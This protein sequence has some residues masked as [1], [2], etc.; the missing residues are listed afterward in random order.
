VS[1]RLLAVG[2]LLGATAST[3]LGPFLVISLVDRGEGAARAA[4]LLA[5]G[6]WL[7]IGGRIVAGVVSDKIPRPLAHVRAVAWMLLACG[8][9]MAVLA[10]AGSAAAV[11]V[12]TLVAM[13]FGWSWPGLLHHAV[14]ATHPNSPAQATS[15]MQTGTYLGSV[16]GPLAFGLAADRWSFSVAWSGAAVMALGSVLSLMVG[17][18]RIERR[19]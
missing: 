18:R 7:V 9:G 6:G 1:L 16:A 10:W 12:G 5:V 2:G 14:I 11:V 17:V 8:A 13:G 3:V 4:G 19:S 15:L